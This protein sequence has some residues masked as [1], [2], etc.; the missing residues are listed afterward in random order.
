MALL[1]PIR[2]VSGIK[3]APFL[4]EHFNHNPTQHESLLL[5]TIGFIVELS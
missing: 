5:T 4:R 2:M 1:K 3:N